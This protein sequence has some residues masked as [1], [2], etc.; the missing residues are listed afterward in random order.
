[1]PV[2]CSVYI[3][4]SVDGFIARN[5]GAIDWLERPEYSSALMNGLL[6]DEF[7]KT[8]DVLVMGR[9]SFEIVRSFG[10]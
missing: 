2:K 4:V 10:F 1:M 6:Y 3:A 8:V 9:H 5:D 7:I